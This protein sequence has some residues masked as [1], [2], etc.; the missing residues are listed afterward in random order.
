EDYRCPLPEGMQMM[1]ALAANG[2]E[3][4]MVIFKGENHELS[5]SGRPKH[6]IRRLK[7]ITG[8]FEV[9]TK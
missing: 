1:Q 8:W 2:V 4:R 9:H 5:R 7:E 6:R 3:T